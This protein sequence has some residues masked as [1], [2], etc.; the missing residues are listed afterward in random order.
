MRFARRL[1][2]VFSSEHR[3]K[4]LSSARRSFPPARSKVSSVRQTEMSTAAE[5]DQGQSATRKLGAIILGAS[6]FPHFPSSRHLDN[7][8]FARSAAAFRRLIADD[9]IS[10]FG[11]PAILDLFDAG[12]G[13]I[14]LIRQIKAFLKS[15][16]G[17][18]D[19]LFYYCGH[20]DFLPD[21]TYYLTLRETEPENEAFRPAFAANEACARNAAHDEARLSRLRLLLLRP[22]GERMDVGRHRPCHRGAALPSLPEA[23][24]GPRHRLC[25]R[26]SRP[27]ARGRGA[28]D[29]HGL[30]RQH[31]RGRGRGRQAGIIVSRCC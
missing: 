22:G 5:V 25:K 11:R 23:R 29:V 19:V 3:A 27:R 1:V 21:R 9:Q 18:T 10:I 8:S 26:R 7:P 16:P 2:Q 13:P 31:H 28:D 24:H 12:D 30:P 20:G 6:R 15:E 4:N 17:L 14:A